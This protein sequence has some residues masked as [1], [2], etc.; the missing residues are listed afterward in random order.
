MK[1]FQN[2]TSAFMEIRP[3][4]LDA[5]SHGVE[6]KFDVNDDLR[7]TFVVNNARIRHLGQLVEN[8]F[9]CRIPPVEAQKWQTSAD[10]IGYLQKKGAI[11]LKS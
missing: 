6:K 5:L 9:M 1:T 2:Q 7:R 4:I 3:L 11:A 10:I 8:H